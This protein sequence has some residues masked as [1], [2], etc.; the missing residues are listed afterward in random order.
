[1]PL[2]IRSAGFGFLVAL[3][4]AGCGVS[5][6]PPHL[7]IA[8]GDA[9]AGR[10]LIQSYGCAVCHTIEGVPGA[11]GIVG[12]PLRDFAQRSTLA[13]S[14]PNVPRHLVNWLID[15]PAMQPGTAMPNLGIT[16][17]QARHIATFLYTQGAGDVE[18]F[19]TRRTESDYPWL[20]QTAAQMAADKERLTEATRTG[21]QHARIPIER[22]MEL[23][24]TTPE[25][26]PEPAR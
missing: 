7:R 4:T 19:E 12:P 21:P 25:L 26:S 15:P 11:V 10:Q 20:D 14:F 6:P 13:G 24:A 1:M 17:E 16:A 2:G 5:E 8:G 23:L 9:D 3:A 22:A 18:T